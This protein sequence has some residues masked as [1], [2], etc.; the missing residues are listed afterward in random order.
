VNGLTE[1]L[2][3]FQEKNSESHERIWMHVEK[4]D[5]CWMTTK[6]EFLLEGRK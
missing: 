4:Q 2:A 6:N 1:S 3:C 5:S